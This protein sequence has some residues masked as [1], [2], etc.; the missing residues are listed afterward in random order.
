MYKEYDQLL[1][2][3]EEGVHD[4]I[5]AKLMDFLAKTKKLKALETSLNK[6]VK[7]EL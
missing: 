6:Q 3:Y 2:G 1:E 4:R 5:E 7:K